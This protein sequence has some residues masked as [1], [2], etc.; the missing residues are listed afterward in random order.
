MAVTLSSHATC[1]LA[2]FAT[3]PGATILGATITGCFVLAA[4]WLAWKSVQAGI[5]AQENADRQKFKLALTAELLVFSSPVIAA[6]SVWN[7]LARDYAAQTPTNWPTLN[8]PRVFE[9]LV[10]LIGLVEGPTAAA[11][12]GFY[13]NVLDLNELSQ[14]AIQGRQSVGET[15]GKVAGRFQ[16]MA[17]YL[18][19]SL[20]GL[21]QDR[22][23]PIVGQDLT[24]LVTPSGVTV[25]SAGQAPTSL[26]Q[27]LRTIGG[28]PAQNA[29]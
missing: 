15:V 12:I 7:D 13:G 29:E 23:F 21:N 27:L 16:A 24:T 9:A 10:S 18:A 20:D 11:L 25:A 3:E 8:R 2:F 26:Q 22:A 28:R 19:A 6:A 4:A 14:E 5:D 17:Q 1:V